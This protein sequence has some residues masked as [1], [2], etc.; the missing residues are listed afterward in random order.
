M[1]TY[2]NPVENNIK[3]LRLD[4]FS[5]LERGNYK[6][7]KKAVHAHAT[8]CVKHF[9]E[10]M[11]ASKNMGK[12]TVPLFSTRGIK[13]AKIWFLNLFRRKSADE[14]LLQKLSID[15]RLREKFNM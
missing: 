9:D 3:R 1:K 2:F 12:Y 4:I 14:K 6:D 11:E 8:E 15:R 10:A 7:Y 13:M 5:A